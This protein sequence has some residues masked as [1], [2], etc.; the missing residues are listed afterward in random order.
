MT[1]GLPA[2][3]MLMFL[4][5]LIVSM[6][7]KKRLFEKNPMNCV[8]LNCLLFAVF[9]ETVGI[10]HSIVSR[11]AILFFLPP[12]AA[13]FPDLCIVVKEY[14]DEKFPKASLKMVVISAYTAIMS[15]F[16]C[17]MMLIGANYNGVMPYKS[18]INLPRTE[19]YRQE[20]AVGPEVR[21]DGYE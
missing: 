10:K 19:L 17:Y 4:V 12:V 2:R 6:F 8:Y 3:Y 18:I 1:V 16:L 20:A 15:A 7:F 5:P 11:F 13:L 21:E 14:I 9:F